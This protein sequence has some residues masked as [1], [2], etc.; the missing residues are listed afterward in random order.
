M[1]GKAPTLLYLLLLV[2]SLIPPHIEAETNGR[3]AAIFNFGD[4]LVD[5]GNLIV[6][7]T[8]DY[9]A[10]AKY[11]YGMTYFGKPTGRCSDGRLV[12]DF[13][14]QEFGI[15]LLPPSKAHNADFKQGANFAITG[16]TALETE[17]FEK[18]GLGQVVWNSGALHTQIKW[19]QDMK[20][21]ICG[22]PEACKELFSRSLFILGEFGGNDYNA[23]LFANRKFKEVYAMMPHVMKSISDGVEKLIA[24]GAVDIVVPGV[25]PVGCFPVY[26]SLSVNMF[27]I[28]KGG[29][30]S[31]SG[32]MKKFNTLA[33][34]HN[35]LLRQTIAEL[36][37]KYP[38]ARIIYADYYSAAIQFILH[39]EKYGFAK[40][41]PRACCGARGEGVYNF[42]MTAKCGEPGATACPD[43]STHW[44]WDGI[45]LTE[46]AYGHIAR[47]WLNGSFADPAII[48]TESSSR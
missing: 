47:G 9:L 24:E 19:F 31:R 27:K 15:P 16:A 33:W 10:T 37:V 5:A 12:I 11:P 18:L 14:C 26:L 44:S 35:S 13:I 3:Y 41:I 22:T 46:A 34:V 8:P 32:C 45:H 38:Q 29:F 48:P 2:C 1:R 4:S 28:K 39:P 36:R 21:Q 17:F 20:P 7:G 43:P 25:L 42:N 40:Q 6:N 30:G 23:P